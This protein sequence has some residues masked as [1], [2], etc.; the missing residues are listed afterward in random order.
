MDSSFAKFEKAS[1]GKLA[2]IKLVE[3]STIG[4]TYLAEVD[5]N[6][7]LEDVRLH[8][9]LVHR[10]LV[11]SKLATLVRKKQ[12]YVLFEANPQDMIVKRYQL[13]IL[14]KGDKDRIKTLADMLYELEHVS[15]G[16]ARFEEN[17]LVRVNDE[18]FFK[19]IFAKSPQIIKYIYGMRDSF[20]RL[21]YY[22]LASPSI[23]FVAELK[24]DFNPNLILNSIIEL[25]SAIT[26][27]GN[28]GHYAKKRS[29]ETK[30]TKDPSLERDER[31]SPKYDEF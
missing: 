13:E 18:E 27:L 4:R 10:H 7:P 26:K 14:D 29:A 21:S 2:A 19:A 22:P 3:T 9:T 11:I 20:H 24:K 23:R 30:I 15:V 16:S 12:D 1:K 8:F 31:K 28:R 17:F 25:T 5:E 6:S